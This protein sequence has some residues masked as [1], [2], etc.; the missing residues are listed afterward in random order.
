MLLSSEYNR[1]AWWLIKEYGVARKWAMKSAY[2]LRY[3]DIPPSRLRAKPGSVM[4]ATWDP[5]NVLKLICLIR[6]QANLV[7]DSEREEELVACSDA[8]YNRYRALDGVGTRLVSKFLDGELIYWA[9]KFYVDSLTAKE[10]SPDHKFLSLDLPH[11]QSVTT[12]WL[13]L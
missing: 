6:N 12:R 10:K 9:T 4:L 5:S 2:Y 13:G 3:I 7:D 11:G 1:L 8:L